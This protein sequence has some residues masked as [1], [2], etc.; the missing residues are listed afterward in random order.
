MSA[1]LKASAAC[2]ASVLTFASLL[3]WWAA[4]PSRGAARFISV[5]SEGAASAFLLDSP[6]QVS[7]TRLVSLSPL[8]DSTRLVDS[9]PLHDSS[10]LRD[11]SNLSASPVAAVSKLKAQRVAA[12][13]GARVPSPV[14]L[15]EDGG[16]GLLVRVWVNGAGPYTFAVDTGAGANIISP[17]VAG[18]ARVEVEAGGRGIQVG[19][20]SGMT[21]GGG[22]KAF[23]RSIA[24][25][26]RDNTLPARGLSIVAA[27]LPTDLDGI[28]DPTEAFSPLGYV[29]DMPRGELR[30]FD[31]RTQPVRRG[32]APGDGAVVPWLTDGSSRRPFVMLEG[33]RRALLDTGSGFGL[34]VDEA[35]AR[36][37]GILT[38]AGRERAGARDIAGGEVSSRRVRA[39]TVSVGPL[40]LRGVPTDFLTRAEKGA[41]I[42]LGRDALRPF[43]LTF[44]P[45][46]RLV[47]FE[48]VEN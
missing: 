8:H 6:G 43:R 16:R 44:D 39:A 30:A 18:E 42:L 3:L 34:A 41:P 32:D 11:S 46:S 23:P 48:P 29:I 28:L 14:G 19:G 12:G 4:S 22:Q 38:S 47:M 37:L 1:S 26:S 31:P 13:Q 9:P 35:A 5:E 27:G 33:G 21:A 20:L 7:S 2:A 10:P 25:G 24:L 40:V 15:R 17:R 45:A 36:S